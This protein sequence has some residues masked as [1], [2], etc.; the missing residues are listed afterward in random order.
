MNHIMKI[1]AVDSK[2]I[3]NKKFVKMNF[4]NLITKI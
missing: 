4:K 2:Q 3:K 1:I